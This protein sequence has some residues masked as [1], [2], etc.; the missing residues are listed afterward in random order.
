MRFNFMQMTAKLLLA[1]F[2]ERL[3]YAQVYPVPR[4]FE[5]S[6]EVSIVGPPGATVHFTTDGSNPSTDSPVF[7]KPFRI[8]SDTVVKAMAVRDGFSNSGANVAHFVRGEVPPSVTGPETLPVAKTGEPYQVKFTSDVKDA[9]WLIQ[10]E[11]VP[12]IPW[13]KTNTTFPNNMSF[14]SESGVW[15]GT[16]Y[17]PGFYWIQVWVNR[18]DGTL[19]S[20]RNYRWEVTGKELPGASWTEIA[21]ELDTNI[22]LAR[23]VTKGGWSKGHLGELHRRLKQRGVKYLLLGEDDEDRMLLV[24]KRDRTTARECV[25]GIRKRYKSLK[26]SVEY[27]D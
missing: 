20:H 22:E 26:G 1:H 11:L 10:G 13:K 19:A 17:R 5:E 3:A 4:V 23:L 24:D 6:T 25:E 18:G 7:E 9:R 14:D 16:P 2:P 21:T 15:S 27:L 12:H 8:S